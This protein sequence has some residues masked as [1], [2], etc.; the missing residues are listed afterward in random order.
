M[1]RGAPEGKYNRNKHGSFIFL[2]S[3]FPT[4]STKVGNMKKEKG[5]K[6]ESKKRSNTLNHYM[7]FGGCIRDS[8]DDRSKRRKDKHIW[9]TATR[10]RK[11]QNR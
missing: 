10:E 3:F 4:R 2:P 5:E 1:T 6:K 9:K 7:I 8:F 11:A